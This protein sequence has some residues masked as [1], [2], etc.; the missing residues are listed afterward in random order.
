MKV[1]KEKL[2]NF[3]F[4][5]IND[6]KQDIIYFQLVLIYLIF[7]TKKKTK[8]ERKKKNEKENEIKW[9]KIGLEREVK[10]EVRP[11]QHER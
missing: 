6:L 4:W 8:K 9:K 11:E 5:I 1:F 10:D 3:L 7:Q 2:I